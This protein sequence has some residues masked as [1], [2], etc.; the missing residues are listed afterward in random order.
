MGCS[1]SIKIKSRNPPTDDSKGDADENKQEEVKALTLLEVEQI[2]AETNAIGSHEGRE[3]LPG[4]PDVKDC[5]GNQK[6]ES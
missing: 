5:D 3:C 4:V 6:E 2:N 1:S